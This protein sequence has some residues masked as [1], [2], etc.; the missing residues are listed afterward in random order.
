MVCKILGSNNPVWIYDP[1]LWKRGIEEKW[2]SHKSQFAAD[3]GY[4]FT[5]KIGG[6]H[7]ALAKKEKKKI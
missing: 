4:Y 6:E 2:Y 3:D 1:H 7:N 5:H